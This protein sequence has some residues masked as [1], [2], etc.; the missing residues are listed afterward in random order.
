MVA[1]MGRGEVGG[2]CVVGQVQH[3][4]LPRGR[5]QRHSPVFRPGVHGYFGHVG[6]TLGS[7]QQRLDGGQR[8]G[9]GQDVQRG[10]TGAGGGGDGRGALVEEEANL[11][12]RAD[13]G[14]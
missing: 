8:A 5:V 6:W 3:P 10:D 4:L 1:G 2:Q 12:L 11:G 7:L 13:G 14:G 9:R